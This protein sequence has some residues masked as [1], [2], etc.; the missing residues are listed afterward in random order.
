MQ[1]IKKILMIYSHDRFLYFGVWPK[2]GSEEKSD[3]T[4]KKK[5]EEGPAVALVR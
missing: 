5:E 1:M 4:K 3:Y 2:A